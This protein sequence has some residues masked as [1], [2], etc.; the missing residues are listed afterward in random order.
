MAFATTEAFVDTSAVKSFI[1]VCVM[2][3]KTFFILTCLLVFSLQFI[4]ML[5]FFSPSMPWNIGAHSQYFI[6]YLFGSLFRTGNISVGVRNEFL[7]PSKIVYPQRCEHTGCPVCS[8]CIGRCSVCSA[9]LVFLVWL[10]YVISC[11]YFLN[12]CLMKHCA[13]CH[14]LSDV[15][16]A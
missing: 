10:F 5:G 6:I 4:K 16:V 1:H 13:N 14:L 3:K 8:C 15:W 9:I 7:D 12:R 11:G 2:L